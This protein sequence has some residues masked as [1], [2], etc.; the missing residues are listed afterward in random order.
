[1]SFLSVCIY[2][3]LALTPDLGGEVYYVE[4][5]AYSTRAELSELAESVESL[6]LDVEVDRRESLGG[7]D[8][9]YGFLV[10]FNDQGLA[11][12]VAEVL[13]SQGGRGVRVYSGLHP[14]QAPNNRTP[15]PSMG[16]YTERDYRFVA[17][18][19]PEFTLGEFRDRLRAILPQ[20]ITHPLRQDVV[21]SFSR[22]KPHPHIDTNTR[23][24]FV[25]R[26]G[27]DEAVSGTGLSVTPSSQYSPE[28][29]LHQYISA[30]D[31]IVNTP[32]YGTVRLQAR[33]DY[34][35]RGALQFLY[36]D[37]TR[38]T[39]IVTSDDARL[40][41][42]IEETSSAGELIYLYNQW[43]ELGEGIALPHVL[44]VFWRG[45]LVEMIEV[46]ELILT[47]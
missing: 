27:Q 28:A 35:G 14:T 2:L 17:S 41:Y 36:N 4:T 15:N 33:G 46:E 3:F 22:Y 21:F 11:S 38:S 6:G 39:L 19:N 26:D 20:G 29:V 10:G 44:E 47:P 40:I 23:F 42:K 18:G 24:R 45:E 37:E 13:A 30:I 16:T 34:E 32:S 9:W 25:R 12:E 31:L 8:T 7:R 43:R 1:L 5:G